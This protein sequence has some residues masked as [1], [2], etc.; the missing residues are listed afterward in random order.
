MAWVTKGIWRPVLALIAFGVA[1]V[2]AACGR[3]GTSTET[4]TAAKATAQV[5][6][7]T[8]AATP[9]AAGAARPGQPAA[10]PTVKATDYEELKVLLPDVA[11]WT[12]SDVA[13]EEVSMPETHSRATARYTRNDS[14]IELDITDTGLSQLLLGPLSVFLAS[15]YTE[16]SDN[17]FKRALTISGQPGLE[18][19]NGAAGRGEVTALVGSRFVVKAIGHDVSSI[20]SVR[21]VV[22]AIDFPRLAAIK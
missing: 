17:G 1:G 13:G 21:S 14:H 20:D 7:G 10:R 3:S 2:L 4:T 12:K 18:D 9:P 16:R 5:P 8:S 22:A 11:G 6:P 19:W 15:G